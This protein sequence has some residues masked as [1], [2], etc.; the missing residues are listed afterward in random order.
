M[1]IQ[2]IKT[3]LLIP[4]KDDL[5]A[6]IRDSISAIEEKSILA[7]ASKVVSIWQGRCVKKADVKDKDDLIK[8]EADYYL[9]RDALPGKWV[10]H[11]IKNNMLIPTAGIDRS[12][13]GDYYILWPKDIKKT[14]RW[15]YNWIRN[16]YNVKDV[17]I[18]FTDSHSIPLRRGLVGISLAHYGF[19]PLKDYRGSKDLFGR[20][21]R[22]SQTNIAD[23]LSAAAVLVMGEGIEQ[24]PLV[25]ISDIEFVEFVQEMEI[26][27][28]PFSSFEIAPEEDLYFSLFMNLGWKKGGGG[29]DL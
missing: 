23:A 4:P 5:L 6:V 2:P 3:R 25:M 20:E 19:V 22:V 1:T 21:L 17:G 14:I 12:N 8:K 13:A 28:K 18:I 29:K 24:T 10:I 15:L 26:S 7:I 11:T 9:D 16:T 27:D